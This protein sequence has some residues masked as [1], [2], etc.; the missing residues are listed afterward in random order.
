MPLPPLL[1]IVG[2]TAVGKTDLALALAE[3]HAIEAVSADSRQIYRGMDVGTAKPTPEE[4]LRLPHH[5]I[6]VVDLDQVLT[7]AE[8]QEAAFAAIAAITACGRLPVL[9]GGT[10]LYVWAVV[11]NWLIPRVA[12]NPDVRRALE[13]EATRLGGAHMH[14]RLAAVDPEAAA[15]IHSANV[16]R[17]IRALEVHHVSGRPISEQQRK[18]PPRYD[19][20]IVGLTGKRAWLY[21]RADRRVD[22]MV[23]RGLVAEVAALLSRGYSTALPAMSGLGYR[24]IADYLEGTYPLAEAVRRVK[25]GTHR[26]IRQQYTW[27]APDDPRIHWFEAPVVVEAVAALVDAWLARS[28][29]P[30]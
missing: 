9:V 29:A 19:S 17:V 8:Y 26:F 15:K 11:E 16:R 28:R 2:P 21:E 30:T 27:F 4:R 1:A 22:A 6:D 10:G 7:L 25:T 14:A 5:L 23:E 12:P 24:Q 3:R 18:G 13:E 20:L